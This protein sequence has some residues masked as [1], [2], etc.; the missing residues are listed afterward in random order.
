MCIVYFPAIT[1]KP[2]IYLMICSILMYLIRFQRSIS[3]SGWVPKHDRHSDRQ[4][5][6]NNTIT[7]AH[8]LRVNHRFPNSYVSILPKCWPKYFFRLVILVSPGICKTRTSTSPKEGKSPW[9]GLPLRLS[10][11]TST[12]QP[13]TSG[14][15]GVSA[16]RYGHLEKNH[17]M[18][19]PIPR[20]V[21]M[22]VC[23]YVCNNWTLITII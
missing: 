17:S 10:S 21:R 19:R 2:G 13:A 14:V 15:T 22:Y 7:L 3:W 11:I 16:M 23:M 5:E 4:T 6:L 20:Y 12:L 18:T 1:V 9:S 8:A